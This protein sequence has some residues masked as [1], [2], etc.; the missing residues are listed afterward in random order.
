MAGDWNNLKEVARELGVHYMTAYRYVRQ[1]RLP[2]TWIDNGWQVRTVDLAAYA[3]A[4]ADGAPPNARRAGIGTGDTDWASRLAPRLVDGDETGAWAVLEAA[5][6]SGVDHRGCYIDVLSGA[7]AELGESWSDG[8]PED[9]VDQRLAAATAL[10]LVHRLGSRFA[11]PG[12]RKGTVVLGAPAGEMHTLPVAIA[13]DLIRLAG[14]T[15]LELGADV[16][17]DTFVA[18]ARR[19]E[20]LVA[21]GLS[22]TTS[23]GV[24][25]ALAIRRQLAGELPGVAVLVGGQAVGN[26]SIASALGSAGW[27]VDGAD[28]VDV[29]NGLAHAGVR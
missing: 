5:M 29:L 28:L 8:R 1:G 18:A 26:P 9:L 15:V 25:A 4:L 2:A 16:D 6:A 3:V 19:A 11:R 17:G 22:L 24:D 12:R 13:A 21:I 7:L 23:A 27:A 10:R 20:R 14:F